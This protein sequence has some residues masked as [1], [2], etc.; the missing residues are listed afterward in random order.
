MKKIGEISRFH[1]ILV[2]YLV[3]SFL[4][5]LLE[6]NTLLVDGMAYVEILFRFEKDG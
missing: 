5:L 1:L 2:G 6:E 3:I 4:V